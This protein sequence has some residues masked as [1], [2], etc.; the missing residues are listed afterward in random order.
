MAYDKKFVNMI[1]ENN[2]KFLVDGHA[3]VYLTRTM[4]KNVSLHFSGAI[5]L[6]RS[7][8]RATLHRIF[9]YYGMTLKYRVHL[10]FYLIKIENVLA[11][12]GSE[13]QLKV[14][15]FYFLTTEIDPFLTIT[16]FL[17]EGK[18]KFL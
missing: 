18:L 13:K 17:N 5:H 6:V 1:E 3:L 2:D 8:L 15:E 10:K 12:F 11:N 14:K 16:P 4:L 9:S 7:N